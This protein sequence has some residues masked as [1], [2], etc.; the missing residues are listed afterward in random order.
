MIQFVMSMETSTAIAQ[1]VVTVRK[2][3][4]EIIVS[5]VT[6]EIIFIPLMEQKVLSIQ[7]MEVAFNVQVNIF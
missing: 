3:T 1:V 5:F 2:A 4:M 6:G 7:P